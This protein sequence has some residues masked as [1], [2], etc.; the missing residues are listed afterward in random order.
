MNINYRLIFFISICLAVV[1]LAS[2]F[3]S[4]IPSLATSAPPAT[5]PESQ[6]RTGPPLDLTTRPQIWLGPQ[7]PG[8]PIGP[9]DYFDL[10]T[11]NAPWQQAAHGTHVFKL[12]GGWI[13]G[14]AKD[15][16][17]R[18][19]VADLQRRGLGIAFE[20]PPLAATDECT[21]LYEGF[22]YQPLG[23]NVSLRIKAAGGTVNY[24][25]LEHPYD[26]VT[27]SGAPPN[28][29]YSAER[30]AQDVA[31]YVQGVRSVF[32]DV[33]IGAIE[34]ADHSVEAV[35][36]WVEAYRAVMG[37][38][39]DYFSLDV[40]YS[41]P[42]WAKDAHAI[43]DY[44]RG[45]GIESGI[46]YRGDEND[47]S[48][49][50]WIAKA[51]QR[52]VE[53]EVIAGGRPDR[54]IFQ[55]WHHQPDHV[56]PETDPSAFTYLVNRYL[57]TRT[58]MTLKAQA[59]PAGGVILSG[60]LRDEHGAPLP[61]VNVELSMTPLE[62]PGV[63]SEY[64]VSG[65]VPEGALQAIAGYRVNMECD[66]CSGSADFTLYEVHYTEGEGDSNRVPN[67]R[68]DNGLQG[69]DAWGEGST[70][71]IIPSDQGSGQALHVTAQ[72]GQTAGL[73]STSFAVTA[74]ATFTATFVARV[75]PAS[76]GSGYF[77]IFFLGS[78]EEVYRIRIPLRAEKVPLGEAV[79]GGSGAFKFQMPDAPAWPV[80]FQAWYAGDDVHWPA[81]AEVK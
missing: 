45:R 78:N 27:F 50:Q 48:S 59:S 67:W 31:V 69:W 68:F 77:S 55:S 20:A 81:Y 9:P 26:A 46:F 38:D 61:N 3:V 8:S 17:L 63:V 23:H 28:C 44:L 62:G 35:A 56:L 5:Q 37:E 11:A 19:I 74:G 25:D 75:A 36:R 30:A 51:E 66:N 42:N 71:E 29:S 47:T 57:R 52:F 60:V 6:I 16:Q 70:W 64:T 22:G 34:T 24:A 15:D 4:T 43:E 65:T 80:L 32:P 13:D 33:R 7:P 10:F 2:S 79:T 39:L 72:P 73:S 40:D 49:A 54:A 1:S 53:Y 18:Q 41:R 21:A 58:K 12:Y 14:P 76:E